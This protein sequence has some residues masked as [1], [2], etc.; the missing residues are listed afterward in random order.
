MPLTHQLPSSPLPTSYPPL[1]RQVVIATDIASTSLTIDGIV[2]VVDAG[3]V[4]Q[5]MYSPR[6]GLDALQV[7]EEEERRGR[8]RRME[9]VGR[10][11]NGK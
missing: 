4:K 8:A 1:H 3:F 7:R 9:E 5:N 10:V 6:T 2:Y 11:L